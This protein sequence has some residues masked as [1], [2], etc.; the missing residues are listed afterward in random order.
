MVWLLLS[1]KKRRIFKVNWNNIGQECFSKIEFQCDS[2]SGVG[3]P[4]FVEETS[5]FSFSLSSL[6]HKTKENE[7]N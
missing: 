1:F 2:N 4:V 5:Y 7:I 3:A 6:H